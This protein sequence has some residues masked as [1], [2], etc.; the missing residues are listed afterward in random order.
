MPDLSLNPG[1]DGEVLK[2]PL[3]GEAPVAFQTIDFVAHGVPSDF[4]TAMTAVEGVVLRAGIGLGVCEEALN[5]GARKRPV[6][7]QS[8]QIVRPLIA[9]C[10]GDFGLTPHGVDGDERAGLPAGGRSV[11][12]ASKAGRAGISLD[13]SDWRRSSRAEKWSNKQVVIIRGLFVS[14]PHS[15]SYKI[16]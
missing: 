7:L 6:V 5:L 11:P 12:S 10:L 3:A 2:A 8:E 13:F 1:H 14:G 4:D 15:Q 9:D 16:T